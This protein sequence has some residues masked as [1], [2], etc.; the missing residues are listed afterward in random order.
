MRSNYDCYLC[1]FV[2][3]QVL[4]APYK[5]PLII[6]GFSF[7]VCSIVRTSKYTKWCVCFFFKRSWLLAGIEWS[8]SITKTREYYGFVFLN[9]FWFVHIRFV[10]I[11]K[12]QST[13]QFPI[14]HIPHSV[15]HVR[16]F[17]LCTFVE[18]TYFIIFFFI[19]IFRWLYHIIRFS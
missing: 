17:L 7:Y 14:D 11:V 19:I 8:L 6:H 12:F 13:V 5:V 3:P 9:R 16:E 4:S 15:I 2:V 1:D 18:F 10:R